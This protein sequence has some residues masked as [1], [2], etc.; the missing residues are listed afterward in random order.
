MRG[1]RMYRPTTPSVDGASAGFGFS[2]MPSIW[3]TSLRAEPQRTMPYWS[4]S[5]R[6]TFC[7]PMIERR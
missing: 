5:S 4:V 7:T 1:D 3:C 2:T 6:V